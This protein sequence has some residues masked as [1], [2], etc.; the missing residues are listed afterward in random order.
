MVFKDYYKILDLDD[1]TFDQEKIKSAYKKQAK[2][3][4]P[5][6]NS[7]NTSEIFNDIYESYQ[8]LSDPNKKRAYDRLWLSYIAR[9]KKENKTYEHQ[10]RNVTIEEEI[11][12]LFLGENLNK[13]LYNKK[14]QDDYEKGLIT[15]EKNIVIDLSLTIEEAF[16]GG[17]KEITFN[18]LNNQTKTI[19]INIPRGVQTGD[20]LQIKNFEKAVDFIEQTNL[21][22]NITV[23]NDDELELKGTNLYKTVDLYP[24]D[25]AFGKKVETEVLGEKIVI[26]IPKHSS[27]NFTFNL[28]QKG[29]VNK[30]GF[31]GDLF[32]TTNMVLPSLFNE[33]DLELYKKLEESF[34]NSNEE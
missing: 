17:K 24:W 30:Q 31:R 32:I 20:K 9:D 33:S 34:N 27:Q 18:N 19:Y 23:L 15:K 10:R 28:K 6:T 11:R 12:N 29:F 25:F 3:Y 26:F 1:I 2:I 7:S 14:K 13:I 16:K 8:I 4:H 22:V 21:V 5:D